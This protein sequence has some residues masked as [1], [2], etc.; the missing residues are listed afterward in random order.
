MAK[1]PKKKETPRRGRS[2]LNSPLVKAIREEFAAEAMK[3]S[4]AIDNAQSNE[5]HVAA[6]SYL[7]AI[8]YLMS[9][10]DTIAVRMASR[11]SG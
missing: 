9:V 1:T 11:A 4:V 3:A 6:S 2:P 8:Q 5:A 7:C 10:V